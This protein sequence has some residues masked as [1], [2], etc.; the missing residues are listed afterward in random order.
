MTKQNQN[1]AK[2]VTVTEVDGRYDLEFLNDNME[3]VEFKEYD[4]K[5]RA[6]QALAYWS[7]SNKTLSA[8]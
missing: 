6:D 1:Q 3:C 5:E 2:F 7:G 4:T 8:V